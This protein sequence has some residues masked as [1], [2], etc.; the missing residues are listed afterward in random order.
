VRRTRKPPVEGELL[1]KAFCGG[2]A[3]KLLRAKLDCTLAELRGLLRVHYHAEGTFR[4]APY[5]NEDGDEVRLDNEDA[6]QNALALALS[7]RSK[8]LRLQVSFSKPTP[9]GSSFECLSWS[10]DCDRW[11]SRGAV[12]CPP[13]R[14]LQQAVS[15]H[16]YRAP[17]KRVAGGG[18]FSTFTDASQGHYKPS[19]QSIFDTELIIGFLSRADNPSK[20]VGPTHRRRRS[21]ALA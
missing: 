3:S 12:K 20:L 4:G 19:Q 5:R 2:K 7:G 11:R 15:A 8:V 1:I 10:L 14:N 9:R 6:C 18:Y 21:N 17:K 16:Q 13:P